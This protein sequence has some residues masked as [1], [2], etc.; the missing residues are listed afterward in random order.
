[1]NSSRP[2]N[3]PKGQGLS[4]PKEDYDANTVSSEAGSDKIKIGKPFFKVLLD[5]LVGFVHLILM[6][7]FGVCSICFIAEALTPIAFAI[8]T[9]I[10]SF[11]FYWLLCELPNKKTKNQENDV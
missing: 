3:S 10:C 2:I 9:G 5:E 1:M 8:G 6:I 4:S 11:A 7:A